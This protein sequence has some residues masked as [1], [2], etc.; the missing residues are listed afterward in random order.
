M[1]KG[2]PFSRY[3]NFCPNFLIMQENGLI[4]TLTLISKVIMAQVEEQ[5]ITELIFLNILR[6]T[7]YVYF[8][9][10]RNEIWL[11]KVS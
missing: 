9:V 8:Y 5:I 3:L 4:K 2:F 11:M 10:R 6:L 1:L 7:D